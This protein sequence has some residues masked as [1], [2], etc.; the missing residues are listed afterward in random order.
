MGVNFICVGRCGIS[1][2]TVSSEGAAHVEG[3][4]GPPASLCVVAGIPLWLMECMSPWL[5][6]WS[7]G[8][9]RISR[10]IY[11]AALLL[12]FSSVYFDSVLCRRLRW[13]VFSITVS[14]PFSWLWQ[15]AL[16]IPNDRD[17]PAAG[18]VEMPN[19]WGD[20][21]TFRIS[22]PHPQEKNHLS[23]NTPVDTHR[24]AYI[25]VL[26]LRWQSSQM[27]T[28]SIHGFNCLDV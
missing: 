6:T 11:S 2:H 28:S 27:C 9:W 8:G 4:L 24:G 16:T 17:V 26:T 15:W 13:S 1:N 5:K 10:K 21:T 3:N 25:V 14:S 22:L 20:A 18:T 7:C 19:L 23:G 12:S